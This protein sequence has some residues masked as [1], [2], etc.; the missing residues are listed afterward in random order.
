MSVMILI[1]YQAVAI[2]GNAGIHNDIKYV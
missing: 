2:F 1:F